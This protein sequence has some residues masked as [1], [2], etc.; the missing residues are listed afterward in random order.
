MHIERASETRGPSTRPLPP[1]C[2]TT[3][4]AAADNICEDTQKRRK[5]HHQHAKDFVCAFAKKRVAL[6]G[7]ALPAGRGRGKGRGKK[8]RGGHPWGERVFP[9]FPPGTS[10]TQVEASR[11]TPP[12]AHIWLANKHMAWCGHLQPFPRVSASWSACGNQRVAAIECLRKLWDQAL[13]LESL[14]TSDCPVV[15]LFCP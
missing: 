10:I 13:S 3:H 5:E 9:V 15:G 4:E 7:P 12:G 6:R 2:C 11:L 1:I 14:S 8:G